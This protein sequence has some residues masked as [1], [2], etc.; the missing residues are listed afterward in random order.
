MKITQILLFVALLLL[1]SHAMAQLSMPNV[2]G[3]HMVLQADKPVKLW[4]QAAPGTELTAAFAGK[5]SRG[6]A[7][8]AGSWSLTLPP[9]SASAEGATLSVSDGEHTLNFDDVLVGEVW[10]ASGQS[11]IQ[12]SL[13]QIDPDQEMIAAADYPHIRFFQARATSDIAPQSDVAGSWSVCTPENAAAYSAVGYFFALKLH[14]ELDVPVAIVQAGWG[15][16]PV[17]AFTR[18][19]ALLSIPEG[20]GLMQQLDQAVANYD[21]AEARRQHEEALKQHAEQLAAWEALPEAE[22]S[23]RAPRRPRLQGHPGDNSNNPTTIWNGMIHPLVGYTMRGA[24]WYQGESNARSVDQAADYGALFRTMIEDWREQWG[25]DFRFLWVQL[26]NF[27]QPVEEP[28]TNHPWAIVQE[29]Q[30]RTLTLPK[31]GMAVTNDIGEAD[32]IHPINKWDVG[33]RLARWALADEY[34]KEVLKSGPLYR[35]HEIVGDTVKV[36]FDFVGDGLMSRD[37]EALRHFEIQDA[38]GTWHWARAVIEDNSVLISHP[39]VSRPAAV[40]YAWAINPVAANLVNSEE[41]PASLFTTEWSNRVTIPVAGRDLVAYQAAPLLE[42][43]G[44]EAFAGSNFIHP[45]KTPSGFTVTASQPG[46]HPHHFGLW[47]PWKYIQ[48]EDRRILCWE[49]QGGKGIVRAISNEPTPS[50]LLTHSVFIDREAPGGP[51]VRLNETTEISVSDIQQEP[52]TGYFLD[53]TISHEVAGEEPITIN[54]FR[55]SGLGYRGTS[56]WDIENSTLLTSAGEGREGANGSRAKWVR[57]EGS[58]DKGGQAGVLLMTH[59]DN[60]SYPE[61]I[62]TWNQQHNGSIFV[63]FNPVMQEDWIFQ[64]GETYTRNYRLFV[65]DG[66]LSPAEADRL[67]QS[68]ADS[69]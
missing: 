38:D 46:D 67:Q 7:D 20:R 10:F 31:T 45:L 62:R 11:N 58:N 18:R 8:D 64:P 61:N 35:H 30:R 15:G 57:I 66:S 27:R 50:G 4:G 65:Y 24:I 22:R 47:W 59:P 6:V 63:N 60:H 21:E 29:H 16:R 54:Q 9:M 56:H 51:Q 37:G 43:R 13:R 2:F 42:P 55:Y 41:L 1:G 32:D 26:A 48:H 5:S 49:L 33:K 25:D 14:V 28:G 40:R 12:W 52:V 34:G 39:E 19:E 36:T 17:E 23:R 44:G 3:D 68:Y 69:K 53:L